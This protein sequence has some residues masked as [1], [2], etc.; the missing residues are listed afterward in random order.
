MQR[1]SGSHV[2]KVAVVLCLVCSLLVAMSAVGLRGQQQANKELFKRKNIL[3]AAGLFNDREHSDS[4]VEALFASV[5]K[6]LVELDSGQYSDAFEDP[7]AYD[8]RKALRDSALSDVVAPEKDVAGV[9]RRE[10]YA[11]VYLVK[12]G[13]G[14]VDQVVLPIR[15]YGLW[16]TLRGFLALDGKTLARSPGET[17]IRG[18]T[19]YEHGETPGLGG[20]VDNPDWKATWKNKRAFDD[21]WGVVIK[22]VKSAESEIEVDALAGATITSRGVTN[23]LRYWLGE[24]GFG[25]FLKN[26]Q[27]ELRRADPAGD[28]N[29]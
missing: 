4:D 12:D 11:F 18:L 13:N 9:K 15:G 14:E 22:L 29:A 24:E 3:A 28:K 27:Q 10:R 6:R 7:E 16:S 17:R 25:P 23:M 21:N 26:L 1:E 20:E 19:Y 8:P 5:E 2:F